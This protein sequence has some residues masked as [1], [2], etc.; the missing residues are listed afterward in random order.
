MKEK[1]GEAHVDREGLVLHGLDK[2]R[3]FRGD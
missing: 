1:N 2:K 3:A